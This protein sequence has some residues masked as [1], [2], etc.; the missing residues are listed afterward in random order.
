MKVLQLNWPLVL[1]VIAAIDLW[2]HLTTNVSVFGYSVFGP[3]DEFTTAYLG[4]LEKSVL[5]IVGLGLALYAQASRDYSKFFDANMSFR[6]Y[7]GTKEL[8]RAL[9]KFDDSMLADVAVDPEWPTLR[10]QYFAKINALIRARD[11]EDDRQFDEHTLGDGSVKYSVK[12]ISG[13]QRYQ[14]TEGEGRM[15]FEYSGSKG[16]LYSDFGI[17]RSSDDYIDVTPR[18][19]FLTYKKAIRPVFEQ[20]IGESHA[21]VG[22]RAPI[23]RLQCLS[24]V[25]F[26]PCIEVITT[27]FMVDRA[28]IDLEDGATT[29][30]MVPI[31]YSKVY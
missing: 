9:S 25:R 2:T 16:L 18:E 22:S 5:V 10:L 24:L 6:V 15:T 1:W 8:E 31:A 27:I 4:T 21:K 13:W 12:M 11:S 7:F 30:A 23:D 3:W 29:A 17:R 19:F 14:M 28:S 26:F 20:Y